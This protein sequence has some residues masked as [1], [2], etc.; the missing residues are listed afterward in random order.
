[1]SAESPASPLPPS[2]Q[3]QLLAPPQGL[4]DDTA[5][6]LLIE[7]LAG[8]GMELYPHQDEALLE[9][10][11]GKHVILA[12]PTG[13][14]KS[15]VALGMHWRAL[16]HGEKTIYTSPIKALVN[17]KFFD[18]CRAFGPDQVGLL[19]GDATV[20]R[21]APILCCTAEILA[22]MSLDDTARTQKWH[23]VMDEFHYYGDRDRG[24]AWQI[25]LLQL[26]NTSF[27][28]MSA[29]L[30]DT[31]R[32]EEDLLKRTGRPVAKVS[33][34]TRPVPLE[35]TYQEIPLQ[36][37]V[38]QLVVEKKAPCY[39]VHFSHREAS[40]TAGALMS[41]DIC[42][43]DEK[44][45]IAE[46]LKEER[47]PSPYGKNLQRLL[48]HGIGLHHAGLL[49]RYRRL[50]EKLAQGGLL[51]IICGTD[52][53][54]VGINVPLRTV[55]L[56]KLSKYDGEKARLV[57]VREFQQIAGRAGRKGYDDRGWVVALAPEHVI[58]NKRMEAKMGRDGKPIKFTRQKPPERG[59][60]PWNE[61]TF[62]RLVSGQAERLDPVFRVDPGLVCQ[63]LRGDPEH[64]GRGIKKV[65]E[66]IGRSH[67]PPGSQL[68][69]R[70][71]LARIARSL[72]KSGILQVGPGPVARFDP[73]LQEDFSL[74][75]TLSLFLVEALQR[76]DT[77]HLEQNSGLDE[78]ETDLRWAEDTLTLVEAICEQPMPVLIAQQNA[79]KTKLVNALKADGVPYEERMEKLE[80]VTWP[81][82]LAAWLYAEADRYAERHPLMNHDDV[83][84]KRIARSMFEDWRTFSEYVQE[85]DIEPAEGVLLRYLSQ[86]YKTLLQNVPERWRS[87]SVWSAIGYLRAVLAQ[88]DASLIEEWE[89]MRGNKRDGGDLALPDDPHKKRPRLLADL[90]KDSK[91]FA[92]R[93]RA[94]AVQFY[95]LL[96]LGD[97]E[98]AATSIARGSGDGEWT[99][100]RLRDK[101][102]S[103]EGELA[104]APQWDSRVR[105]SDATVVRSVSAVLWSVE[106]SIFDSDGAS[107]LRLVL[108]A[109]LRG[110]L[111]DDQEPQLLWLVE[112]G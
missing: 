27:L 64:A 83:R 94:D 90:A 7:W 32:I 36:E 74:H 80:G 18:L 66:L 91:A 65:A 76:L 106:V 26:E 40:E 57:Q 9:L 103:L 68:V 97:F 86:V 85:L 72:R 102:L 87:E 78:G 58:A 38:S 17:E 81:K 30:G 56:T 4:D 35:Y 50:V 73:D 79:E 82:P 70:R 53:L 34:V 25:P 67:L 52:T 13:S 42:T 104:S 11:T 3:P 15:L 21:D 105:L 88:T 59:Y 95:R 24:M 28:L 14:G 109:D 61:E 100:E 92:A 16:C 108:E 23:V 29:T 62:T 45:L 63:V 98:Q 8:R 84:P 12:T 5:L 51:K 46:Q 1:M 33:A 69:Q 6:L 75:H 37:V 93:L 111:V 22:F 2:P 89:A 101:W 54:G 31:T 99:A 20:H 19:T 48:R 39:L 60:V 44:R 107:D 77:D 110:E 47:W 55:V 10:F 49:P 112:V 71:E 43:K 96:C 41:V